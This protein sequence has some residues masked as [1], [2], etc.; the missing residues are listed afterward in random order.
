VK[1]AKKNWMSMKKTGVL[2]VGTSALKK[3]TMIQVDYHESGNRR[4]QQMQHGKM[5]TAAIRP[6]TSKA[7]SRFDVLHKALI[8]A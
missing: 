4:S 7:C 1:Y 3:G 5:R 8:A 2:V 6:R